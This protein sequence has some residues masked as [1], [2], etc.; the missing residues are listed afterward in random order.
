MP[1]DKP[2]DRLFG[3]HVQ[4]GEAH[5]A[6]R[7]SRRSAPRRPIRPGEE[8][9]VLAD[10]H[11]GVGD[12]V[13]GHEAEPAA[14]AVGIVD[15]REAVDEGVAGVGSRAWP[16]PHAG[17]LARPVGTDVAENLPLAGRQTRRRRPPGG[18][19]VPA[20]A[21]K[22]DH[23]RGS[24]HEG[25]TYHCPRIT[26]D[27][28]SF[29]LRRGH[30]E[31]DLRPVLRPPRRNCPARPGKDRPAA[32]GRI[33]HLLQ[34]AGR[35]GR[36]P[37]AIRDRTS[38]LAPERPRRGPPETSPRGGLGSAPGGASNLSRCIISPARRRLR[39]REIGSS[40]AV[41]VQ[42]HCAGPGK[43]FPSSVCPPAVAGSAFAG[44]SA[45]RGPSPCPLP[46]ATPSRCLHIPC[47]RTVRNCA[48]RPRGEPAGGKP[49]IFIR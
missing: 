48:G 43:D 25:I 7:A 46:P 37:A 32:P 22:F 1:F 29:P 11:V 28:G 17:G 44:G 39:R 21:S 42:R 27:D 24:R 40:T 16:D 15:H 3:Q 19:E 33:L 13:V 30:A 14:D 23:G 8:V 12:E 38:I 45:R 18:A 41:A 9:E 4:A 49:A 5:H 10:I 36:V 20:Q 34:P 47:P 2:V 31:D 26:C 6:S 35:N